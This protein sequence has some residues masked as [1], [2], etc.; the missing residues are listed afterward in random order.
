MSSSIEYFQN[1]S[2]IVTVKNDVGK[3]SFA[4]MS[5]IPESTDKLQENVYIKR[6]QNKIESQKI[7]KII[8]LY[9]FKEMKIKPATDD[10]R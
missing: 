3:S 5:T 7:M 2:D 8:Y 4:D 6:Y 9:K 1:Y 10:E